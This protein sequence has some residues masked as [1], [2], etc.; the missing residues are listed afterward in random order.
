MDLTPALRSDLNEKSRQIRRGPDEGD[1]GPLTHAGTASPSGR[2]ADALVNV[3][4]GSALV[5]ILRNVPPTEAALLRGPKRQR[6][7]AEYDRSIGVGIPVAG[8]SNPQHAK[9]CQRFLK[10]SIA[11]GCAVGSP[12]ALAC[13]TRDNA[14]VK[15]AGHHR[16]SLSDV[17]VRM[18]K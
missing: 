17:S 15:F 5:L 3:G 14:P 11:D 16:A 12:G 1:H 13:R 18:L 6:D 7:R 2:S 8:P 9:F 10:I 4:L